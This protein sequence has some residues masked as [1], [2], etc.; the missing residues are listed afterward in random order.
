MTTVHRVKGMRCRLQRVRCA[1]EEQINFQKYIHRNHIYIYSI[2][3][4]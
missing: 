1:F 4:I 2:F 3:V